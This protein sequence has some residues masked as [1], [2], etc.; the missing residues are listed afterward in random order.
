MTSR[1]S[2]DLHAIDVVIGLD[3]T[4]YD[5]PISPGWTTSTKCAP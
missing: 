4:R 5:C 2:E 1:A 3:G